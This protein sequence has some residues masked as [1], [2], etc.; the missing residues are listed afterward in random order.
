MPKEERKKLLEELSKLNY[1][2][3]LA[4]LLDEELDKLRS[5]RYTTL[6][7]YHG[8]E[9]AEEILNNIFVF[10]ERRNPQKSTKKVNYT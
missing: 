6:D 8:R 3:A 2:T 1:G 7:K 9:M 10:L 5:E 4:D